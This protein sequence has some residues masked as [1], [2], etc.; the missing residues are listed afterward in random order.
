MKKLIAIVLI[1]TLAVSFAGV[2]V[3]SN[4]AKANGP[5]SGS[6]VISVG[7][8]CTV[9]YTATNNVD[10]QIDWWEPEG[11]DQITILVN[12]CNI[13][14]AFGGATAYVSLGPG[15]YEIAFRSEFSG[16]GPTSPIDYT[17]TPMAYTGNYIWPCIEPIIPVEVGGEVYPVDRLNMLAPWV[18]LAAVLII[19]T[20]VVV[21]HRRAPS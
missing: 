15:Y 1:V 8:N 14:T 20:A 16:I 7:D 5:I 12:S 10:L 18:A 9:P 6:C 19:G 4:E 2:L 21:R 17:I 13:S 3:A 11:D